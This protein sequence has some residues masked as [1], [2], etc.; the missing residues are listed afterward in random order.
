VNVNSYLDFRAVAEEQL[1]ANPNS[2]LYFLL[3][4][5]G[6]PGLHR[7]LAGGSAEWTSLFE[8]TKEDNALSVAPILVLIGGNGKLS[9]PRLLFEW[10]GEHGTYTS[11]VIMLAS[12]LSI[13][14]MATRLATR[15]DV[16]L[17]ENMDGML[18]FFDPRIFEQLIH[19]LSPEQAHVFFSPAEKWWYVDRAGKLC[20]IH[21]EFDVDEKFEAPLELSDAQEFQ[22]LDG[23]EPDQVL[24]LLRENAPN[25]MSRLSF[26]DQYEFPT[27]YE[28]VVRQIR[29]ARTL[30][31]G[32][33][34]D[35]VLYSSAA[36]SYGDDF[37]SSPIWSVLLDEAKLRG[38]SFSEAVS[39]NEF[40]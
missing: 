12:I 29:A 5:A 37:A 8:N 36:L 31:L 23:S 17:S 22:L 21:T 6:M 39:T 35:F 34:I 38:L 20:S 16:R 15:L 18:R 10:I 13:R 28:F 19:V 30:G 2:N 14:P 33:A 7:K 1:A 26:S 25:L 27:Q 40:V 4:H 9:L 11:S 32:S 24:A 3:D